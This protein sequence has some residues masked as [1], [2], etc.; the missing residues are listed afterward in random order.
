MQICDK[1]IGEINTK[2]KEGRLTAT[3]KLTINKK[4]LKQLELDMGIIPGSKIITYWGLRVRE[5]ESISGF[6]IN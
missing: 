1:I 4:T 3:S 6:S 2:K 5:D